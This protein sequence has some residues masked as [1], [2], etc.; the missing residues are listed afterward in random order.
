MAVHRCKSMSMLILLRV[1]P[2]TSGKT[3]PCR[4]PLMTERT[5]SAGLDKGTMCLRAPFTRQFFSLW[6]LH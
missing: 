1:R 4:S 5:C 6:T 3:R 2:A